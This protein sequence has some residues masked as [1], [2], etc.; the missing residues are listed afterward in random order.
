MRGSL[1]RALGF[2]RIWEEELVMNS[3]PH[4][5]TA[6]MSLLLCLSGVA[7]G[8]TTPP[9][10][11]VVLKEM[12][13][14]YA[15]LSSYQ[16][17]G[18]VR[19]L[20]VMPLRESG[21]Q[22]PRP[23]S[24]SSGGDTLVSFKTYYVRPRMLRF[25]WKS[26]R[27][28]VSREAAFW[29]D[30]E[31]AYGWMPARHLRGEGFELS[32]SNNLNYYAMEASKAGSEAVLLIPGLL[33]EELNFFPFRE[34]VLSM[35]DSSLLGD[36]QVEGEACHVIGGSVYGRPWVLWVGKS[37]RLLRKTRTPHLSGSFHNIEKVSVAEEIHRDIRINE[38]IPGE[39]FKYR[40]RLRANDVDLTQ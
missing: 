30:G 21:P 3:Y 9:D 1:F 4:F 26:S 39:V 14:R 11:K 20:P 24:E 36:E 5:I 17:T 15:E 38:N 33:M 27:R 31:K 2:Y 34:G 19:I 6:A 12:V 7:Y 8:Q 16:D 23:K 37:S 13:A 28:R 29:T 25:E 10:P 22:R 18:G 40:P 35:T 32:S